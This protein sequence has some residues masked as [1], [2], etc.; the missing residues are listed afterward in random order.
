MYFYIVKVIQRSIHISVAVDCE[1][2]SKDFFGNL[3]ILRYNRV[4]SIY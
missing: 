4:D 3:Y 2:L 1:P